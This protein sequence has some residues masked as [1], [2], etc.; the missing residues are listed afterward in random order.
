ML[1]RMSGLFSFSRLMNLPV[2]GGTTFFVSV[3]ELVDGHF[4][5]LHCGVVGVQVFV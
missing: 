5:G 2:Y 1:E 4:G 3:H